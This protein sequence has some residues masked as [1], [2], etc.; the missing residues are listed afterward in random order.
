[1]TTNEACFLLMT[2]MKINNP[3][4][5]LVLNMGKPVKIMQII[6]SLINL[7]KKIDP[8][9]K[10][11]IKVIGLQDGEKMNEELTIRKKMVKTF[12]NDI[13]ITTDPVYKKKDLDDLILK[14]EF[15]DD[16]ITL[17]KLM[18]KFINQDFKK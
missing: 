16:P 11:E 18:K 12:D 5:V 2:T 7:R 6:K 3:K 15:N 1:M 10:Q 8:G 4:N 9:Y 14:L 17:M 13:S